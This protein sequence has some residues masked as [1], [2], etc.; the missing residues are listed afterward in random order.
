MYSDIMVE[1]MIQARERERIQHVAEGRAR[2]ALA[3]NNHATAI[4]RPA[5]PKVTIGQ[6]FAWLKCRALRGAAALA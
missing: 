5:P 2:T 4:V 6:G 1:A 3:M